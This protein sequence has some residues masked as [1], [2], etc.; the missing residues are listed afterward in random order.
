MQVEVQEWKGVMTELR[1]ELR[2][3]L[4][5]QVEVQEWKGVIRDLEILMGCPWQLLTKRHSSLSSLG[6][7]LYP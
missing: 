2:L 6:I 4:Y 3:E 5:I 7:Q 1:L